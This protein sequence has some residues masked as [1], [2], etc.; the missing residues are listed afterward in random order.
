MLDSAALAA[1]IAVSD[2][3]I[4][5][6]Y[7]QNAKQ[8]SVD[9]LRR[10]SHILISLKK[11]MRPTPTRL[12]QRP[13]PKNLLAQVRKAPADFGKVAKSNS[14]DP[15]S[16]ERG[17]DLDFFGK[18]MMVKPFEDVAFKLKEGEISDLVQSDFGYHIIQLTGVKPATVKPLDEVKGE[19]A[20]TIKKSSWR[21]KNTPNWRNNLPIPSTNRLT[22]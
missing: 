20:A 19:I 9:E 15:G 6:Y 4:K 14:Q 8:Y 5:A 16:A 10:A 11:R 17:G 1:Q 22:A 7:E 12:Q 2:A 13:K 3:D 21:Q 18:G